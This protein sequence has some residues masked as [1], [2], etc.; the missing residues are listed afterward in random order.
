L[1]CSDIRHG[2]RIFAFR[3]PPIPQFL[4]V[5]VDSEPVINRSLKD[6]SIR[7]EAGEINEKLP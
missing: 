2:L 6:C 5:G 3:K 4:R 1:D 7:N